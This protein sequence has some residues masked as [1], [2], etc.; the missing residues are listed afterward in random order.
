[1]ATEVD[2]KKAGTVVGLSGVVSVGALFAV[3]DQRYAQ[4]S[5]VQL[6]VQTVAEERIE[7]VEF[8]IE[9]VERRLIYLYQIPEED[10]SA[11]ETQQI[12]EAEHEKEYLL[13][14]LERLQEVE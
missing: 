7:R 6:L 4:A 1:M 5:D 8:E 11:W 13:R 14:K 3:L 12:M 9:S 10:R 2:L